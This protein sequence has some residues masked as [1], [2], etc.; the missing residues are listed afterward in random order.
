MKRTHG[1]EDL[2]QVAP[3]EGPAIKVDSNMVESA[4]KEMK[5]GKAA[6]PSGI[7]AEMLKISGE[8]GHTLVNR[9]VNQVIQGVAYPITGVAV[10]SSTATRA[11]EVL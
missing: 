11:K 5:T 2:L 8:V 6:G 10:S 3:T 7:V 1:R 4:I 9:S